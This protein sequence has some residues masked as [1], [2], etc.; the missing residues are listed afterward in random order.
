MS[1]QTRTGL[2][3]FGL[4]FG[5]FSVACAAIVFSGQTPSVTALPQF[6]SGVMDRDDFEKATLH[7]TKEEV[8]KAV[9][10]PDVIEGESHWHYHKKTKHRN[11]KQVDQDAYL[12]FIGG[13]VFNVKFR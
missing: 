11:A 9:G 7:K 8:I 3:A 6:T 5:L 12:E 10:K 4:V 13:Q 1:Q 2:I